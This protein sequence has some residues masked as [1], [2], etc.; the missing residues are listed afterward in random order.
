MFYHVHRS[1]AFNNFIAKC[2][3]K[4]PEERSCAT[5]LLDVS[6]VAVIVGIY[7][8]NFRSLLHFSDLSVYDRQSVNLFF[9]ENRQT[10]VK[11][12]GISV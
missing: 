2:L 5:E 6:A 1:S 7:A 11:Q 3:V 9:I 12:C 8:P 10:T 4:D